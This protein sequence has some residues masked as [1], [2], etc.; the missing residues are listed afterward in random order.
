MIGLQILF[1]HPARP[2]QP[3]QHAAAGPFLDMLAMLLFLTFNGHLWLI[4]LVDSFHTLPINDQP[5][6][7]TPSWR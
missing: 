1:C 2:E 7:P 6:T 3:D 4:R 5:P